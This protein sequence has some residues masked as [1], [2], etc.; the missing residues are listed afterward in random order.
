[1]KTKIIYL[2]IA[3][4]MATIC[5]AQVTWTF[6]ETFSF[7]PND[8]AVLTFNKVNKPVG[9]IQSIIVSIIYDKTGGSY[10]VD[11]E[12]DNSGTTTFSHTV[13]GTLSSSDVSL[14]D[15]NGLTTWA[16]AADAVSSTTGFIDAHDNSESSD[17]TGNF[18]T[19]IPDKDYFTFS[20]GDTSASSSATINSAFYGGYVGS[21]TYDITFQANQ[22]FDVAL[23]GGFSF[24]GGPSSVNG[25]VRV[26][27]I[28][29]PEVGTLA[30]MAI[31]LG[32]FGGIAL[33]RRRKRA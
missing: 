5:S 16:N 3:S 29:I 23:A 10:A 2:A 13:D 18:D 26:E 7:V 32:S 21:G 15:T 9:D 22:L 4:I 8:S 17:T 12:S 19:E 33:L 20:P 27:Y 24:Q 11:N 30:M 31:A 28:I 6:E 14:A 1:M 25:L